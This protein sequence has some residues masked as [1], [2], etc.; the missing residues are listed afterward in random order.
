MLTDEEIISIKRISDCFTKLIELNRINLIS[1]NNKFEMYKVFRDVNKITSMEE[2]IIY[3]LCVYAVNC[4]ES[5][6][7]IL[8]DTGILCDEI[9]SSVI[10]NGIRENEIISPVLKEYI[11]NNT[12]DCL[13]ELIE[14][15]NNK[16]IDDKNQD[17]SV[18][19]NTVD[20]NISHLKKENIKA[21]ENKNQ[22]LKRKIRRKILYD[23]YQRR[24]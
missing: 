16:Y 3:L 7:I 4:D 15:I 9:V 11:K 14:D 8:N 18:Y 19:V 10:K 6:M 1:T 5:M 17:N 21:I 13:I 24:Y 23:K 20:Y 12:S 2:K 22:K